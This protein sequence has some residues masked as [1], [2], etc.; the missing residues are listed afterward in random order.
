MSKFR[1]RVAAVAAGF[2][3]L[4][5]AWGFVPSP[6]S[7]AANVTLSVVYYYTSEVEK[8]FVQ[9]MLDEYQQ[10][11]PGIKLDVQVTTQGK[12]PEI[13]TTRAIA[14]QLPDVAMSV[15]Q[16]VGVWAAAGLLQDGRNY[17]PKGLLEKYD[18]VRVLS[19]VYKDQIVGLPVSSTFW[20]TASTFGSRIRS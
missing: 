14:K 16:R 9:K 17:L 19:D 1:K 15:P 7:G 2:A 6:V 8:D 3:V 10:Q 13:M 4:A 18:P 20:R 12:W 5:L 11:H